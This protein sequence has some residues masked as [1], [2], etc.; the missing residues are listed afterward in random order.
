MVFETPRLILRRFT[1]ADT[2]LLLQLNS[3]PEVLKYLHEPLLETEEQ[4]M[5]VLQNIILP[6]YKNN[7]GRWAIHLKT[8]NE[9]I[10]WCGL[11][12]RP[13]LDEIDLGYRLMQQYWGK[14]YAFE[15][16]KHTVDYGFNQ[17]HLKTITGRAHIE[18]TASL[19]IL[20]KVGLQFIKEEVVDDCP[21]KTFMLSK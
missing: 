3:D 5:H 4:A 16:A 19:R 20:G 13:E 7:L 1:E 9:F 11:K 10:G 17:L 2:G 6:Q 15:A 21:V 8:S 14:G 12:Y 18:N